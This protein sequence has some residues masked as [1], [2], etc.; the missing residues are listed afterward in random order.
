[1]EEKVINNLNLSKKLGVSHPTI[2][3]WVD[4]ATEGKNNLQI[5]KYHN[6]YQVVENDHNTAELSRLKE[7]AVK[8]RSK[9][10][11]QTI[12]ANSAIY[13]ILSSTQ[14][15]ELIYTLE[16][17]RKIPLKFTCLDQGAE[18]WHQSNNLS[19]N[20]KLYIN[21]TNSLLLQNLD[22]IWAKIAG[23]ENL[24]VI[25]IG[26][27]NGVLNKL[28]LDRCEAQKIN[29]HYTALNLSSQSLGIL[30]NNLQK[31]YPGLKITT[32]V[33][34]IE[35]DS[36][37]DILF[38]NRLKHPNSC[39]LITGLDSLANNL[40]HS[41]T[42]LKNLALGLDIGDFLLFNS[43]L[44]TLTERTSFATLQNQTY[45]P[46][47]HWLA[48]KLGLTKDLY[49]TENRFDKNSNSQIQVIKLTT[50][51]EIVFK[52]DLVDKALQFR[53]GD[54]IIIWQHYLYSLENLVETL[55][56][57][58]LSPLHLSSSLSKNQLLSFSEIS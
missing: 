21:Q 1:M 8:Y 23:Y 27:A 10:T 3:R 50:D 26:S 15:I 48:E 43:E 49:I 33:G 4:D 2:G 20:D 44:D 18:Y 51:L 13:Q 17:Q 6:K 42:F 28:L 31:W 25:D 41:E 24:C 35:Q 32:L 53:D 47:T 37:R 12:L 5:V 16:K 46:Q 39:N 58:N 54:E 29:L 14:L 45:T 56:S 34:D 22:Y 19:A 11:F 38:Q 36:L 57:A 9:N 52:F 30:K 40:L 55:F 7:K